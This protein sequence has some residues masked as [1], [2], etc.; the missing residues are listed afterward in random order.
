MAGASQHRSTSSQYALTGELDR[1]APTN[2]DTVAQPSATFSDHV[3]NL[4]GP[5]GS[6]LQYQSADEGIPRL[7]EKEYSFTLD[8]SGDRQLDLATKEAAD[9]L[10]RMLTSFPTLNQTSAPSRD[11]P[12]VSE[13]ATINEQGLNSAPGGPR[14]LSPMH[15]SAQSSSPGS[16]G[17]SSPSE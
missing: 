4:Q 12:F 2:V 15:A 17:S 6:A 16:Y 14:Y 8:V 9:D 13:L 11:Q 7:T 5:Q 1:A 10:D 3:E